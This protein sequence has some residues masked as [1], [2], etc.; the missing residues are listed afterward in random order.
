MES[1]VK[2]QQPTHPYVF[3]KKTEISIQIFSLELILI[4]NK[5]NWVKKFVLIV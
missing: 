3:L 5:I 4:Q 1:I 2:Q